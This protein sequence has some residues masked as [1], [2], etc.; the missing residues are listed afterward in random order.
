MLLHQAAHLARCTAALP[1]LTPAGLGG[2]WE[3][4]GHATEEACPGGAPA[5]VLSI[6]FVQTQ[7]RSAPLHSLVLGVVRGDR[8]CPVDLLAAEQKAAAT[9][10]MPGTKQRYASVRPLRMPRS[11][12]NAPSC[13]ADT[14]RW[15]ATAG[16]LQPGWRPPCIQ[17]LSSAARSALSLLSGAQFVCRLSSCGAGS[18]LINPVHQGW[19]EPAAHRGLESTGSE[20]ADSG[21]QWILTARCRWRRAATW[22]ARPAPQR[23][24][25]RATSRRCSRPPDTASAAART[26]GCAACGH[27]GSS[28]ASGMRHGTA[29]PRKPPARAHLVQAHSHDVGVLLPSAELA[30]LLQH[31]QLAHTPHRGVGVAVETVHGA[32]AH[33]HARAAPAR[34]EEQRGPTTEAAHFAL[35]LRRRACGA[36]THLLRSR[37]A[38]P[39]RPERA[40]G[41]QQE[42]WVRAQWAGDHHARAG[43]IC[44]V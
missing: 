32:C 15:M 2:A 18:H 29:R 22:S 26:P 33:T 7:V 25:R 5:S 4:G 10:G 36:G 8:V 42:S 43:T 16:Q 6:A 34:R 40:A 28:N 24:A 21:S 19:I 35:A 30:Q 12:A 1:C 41:Q 14:T 11:P 13:G 17:W 39:A 27:P 23:P 37:S 44:C 38:H 9:A 31:L 3:A 20:Q